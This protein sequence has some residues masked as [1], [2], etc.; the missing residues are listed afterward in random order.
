MKTPSQ[1]LSSFRRN[2]ILDV[3]IHKNNLIIKDFHGKRRNV[4]QILGGK[5]NN[6]NN[7]KNQEIRV[8]LEDTGDG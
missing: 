5:C 2:K 3:R 1:F 8:M 4:F 6:N 7:K